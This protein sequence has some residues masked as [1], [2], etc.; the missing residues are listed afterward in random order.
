M[1]GVG[2]TCEKILDTTMRNLPYKNI[3]V[4][5]VWSFVGKKQPPMLR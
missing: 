1:I 4:D 2:D 5:E 3:E